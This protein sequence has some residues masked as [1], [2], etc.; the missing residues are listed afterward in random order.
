MMIVFD[1]LQGQVVPMTMLRSAIETDDPKT[2]KMK[3][4]RRSN[5]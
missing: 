1:G 4:Q 2:M 3:L 5:V